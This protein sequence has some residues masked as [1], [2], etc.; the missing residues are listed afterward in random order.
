MQLRLELLAPARNIDIG[1]SAIDCGADAVYIAGP[2]FGAREAASNP[3]SDI[4]KLSAY[5]H[6]FGARVYMTLNTILYDSELPLAAQYI[7]EAAEAG[8]DAIIIQ[9]LGILK[10]EGLPSIDLYA[11]TQCNI[12]TPEQ[13]RW[14]ESLGF[15]RLILA[16]ELSLEQIRAIRA[17]TT[18][19][20]ES[21]VH[22]ALCVSYSGQ[23]YLSQYLTGRSANR[24][25]CIQACRS[26]YDLTDSD[27]KVLI[28]NKPLLSLKDLCL[29]DHIGALIDAGITSFKIE[30]R[31]KSVSYVK[32][33]TRYYRQVID[34]CGK[35]VKSSFGTIAGGFRPNPESTFSRGYT[36][37]FIEN[38]R[39]K[40]NSVESS[41]SLGEYIGKISKVAF[42]SPRSC[43]FD[44][45]PQGKAPALSNGDGLCI[46][47][48]RGENIGIRADI[49]NGLRITSKNDSS[50]C[51]GSSVYRNLNRKFE[52]ELEN[53]MPRR[54]LH[55][56]ISIK[57]DKESI[58]LNASAE[59]GQTASLTL[60]GPFQEAN[61][62]ELAL[63]NLK[64][65]L[66]KIT[67]IFQFSLEEVN[68]GFIPF[69]SLSQLNSCR[70]EL[71]ESLDKE[72][73]EARKNKTEG[74]A[75]GDK[76]II[77]PAQTV[78]LNCSNRL[79]KEL[80]LQAGINPPAAFELSTP[81]NPPSEEYSEVMRTK[82][83]IK[84][85][86]GLCPKL[87]PLSERPDFN[88][89]LYLMNNGKRLRL[90]FDC[91]RCEM[92]IIV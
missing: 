29:A 43:T 92:A 24:G 14:L 78:K 37:F 1:I 38:E 23:C 3:I 67:G 70:R 6:R 51:A 86:L 55:V 47:T 13:A 81:Q 5:A 48:P 44:I 76:K 15:K 54:L 26:K 33:V 89:P 85:E 4:R 8:C 2:A 61:N 88:E 87:K 73:L 74:I 80:Y 49:A 57:A 91:K 7:R 22:G 59:N 79:S 18:C 46:I 16:R 42:S 64:N 19:E 34:E 50:I 66:G 56:G 68:C 12:R 82:Y 11:S 83:C 65:Q 71:A 41:K 58:C 17:A 39:G 69:L 35:G 27:G 63:D 52:K 72:V 25:S 77:P 21:F 90:L 30:G 75:A 40:W 53:N 60:S 9:D 32:N 36:S 62:K 31:L 28:R 45:A 84:Y 20:L 10:M